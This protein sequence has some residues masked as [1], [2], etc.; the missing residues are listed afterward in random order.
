MNIVKYV[1]LVFTKK[2]IF[3]DVECEGK[4]EEAIAIE[5]LC[6]LSIHRERLVVAWSTIISC[7][8]DKYH[9]DDTT[10]FLTD[11]TL[12]FLIK[13]KICIV[14][15]GHLK[16]ENKWLNQILLIDSNCFEARQT[17]LQRKQMAQ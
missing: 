13:N 2:E 5:R 16:L 7:I 12:E 11:K 14:D 10:T 15:L 17:I 1:D 6:D 8:I 3:I 4:H 9:N